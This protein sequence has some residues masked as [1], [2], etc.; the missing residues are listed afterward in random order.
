MK[1][2][3]ASMSDD[4]RLL[5]FVNQVDDLE[6]V[7]ITHR[8]WDEVAA[9]GSANPADASDFDRRVWAEQDLQ[10]V[11]DADVLVLLWPIGPSVGAFVEYGYALALNKTIIL[12]GDYAPSI[13]GVLA[14]LHLSGLDNALNTLAFLAKEFEWGQD[15]LSMTREKL[16]SI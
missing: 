16:D 1:I 7:E 8:W 14:D 10:G 6:G 13:F 15:S 3:I 4:S 9:V 12:V 5:G 11:A 2:Y